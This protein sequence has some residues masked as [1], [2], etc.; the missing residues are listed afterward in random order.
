[1]SELDGWEKTR[2][3]PARSTIPRD[4]VKS[5]LS[6]RIDNTDKFERFAA[7]LPWGDFQRPPQMAAQNRTRRS[8]KNP[9]GKAQKTFK[10]AAYRQYVRV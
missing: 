4:S 5:S 9:K 2:Y 8:L 6:Q 1:L 10:V 7:L 3:L